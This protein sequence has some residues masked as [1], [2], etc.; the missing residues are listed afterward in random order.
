M[1]TQE[2][3]TRFFK[4]CEERGLAPETRRTYYSFLRHFADKHPELPTETKIIEAYLKERKETPAH[5]GTVFKKLQAFYSYL[6][7]FEGVK[8]PVPPRGPMGRPRKVKLV[9]NPAAVELG[10]FSTLPNE[11]VVQGGHSVSTSTSISTVDAV[12]AFIRSKK[13][14]G[15]SQRTIDGYYSYFKPFI[16]KYPT[17]PLT[18]EQIEDFLDSLKVDQETKWSYNKELKALYHYL[19]RRKKI[20]KDLFEFP[21]V[22]VSRKV[23]RVLTEDELRRLFQFA[24]NFQE[25]AILTTL[26]DSKVRASELVS[27]DRENVFPDHIVVDAKGGGQ[28]QVP[29]SPDTYDTLCQLAANGPLFRLYGKRMRREYLRIILH[30]LMERA[31]LKGEKLGPHILRHSASV[32]HMMA[33]GDLLSLKEELGHTTTRQTEKYGALAFPQVKQKHEQL[34]VLGRIV[35]QSVFERARCYGCHHEIVLEL[36]KVKETECPECHQ[37]GKWYLP[38]HRTEGQISTLLEKKIVITEGSDER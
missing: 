38:N 24:E 22:K 18:V 20:P 27:L 31:G 16:L 5:R 15:V 32:Q 26:I 9:T 25:K 29:I 17:L 19:E 10:D 34:N 30:R 6:E 1:K 11:K 36:E 33:G 8:S 21:R 7:Q 37:V 3:L 14:E 23:R 4:K 12:K 13:T 2:A 28:R 35:G